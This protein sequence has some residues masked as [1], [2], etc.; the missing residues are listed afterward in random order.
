[1]SKLIVVNLLCATLLV[2]VVFSQAPAFTVTNCV[3]YNSGKTACTQ[4]AAGFYVTGSGLTC[5]ACISNCDTCS[6]STTC[7]TRRKGYYR[8]FNSTNVICSN[9]MANCQTCTSPTTCSTCYSGYTV[10]TTNGVTTCASSG[11]SAIIGLIILCCCCGIIA[12][13][14]YKCYT[15][16]KAADPFYNRMDQNSSF[17]A[18]PYQNPPIQNQPYNQQPY[19]Q[20]YPGQPAMM[21]SPMM[22]PPVMGG[23]GPAPAGGQ[24]PPGWGQ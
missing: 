19:S 10:S 3:T 17:T 6:D 11:G 20:P 1:M 22:P 5:S 14:I 4:C 12:F 8:Y 2:G 18:Q 7:S 9:C 24:L 13:V 21:G 23:P 16:Q 15:A